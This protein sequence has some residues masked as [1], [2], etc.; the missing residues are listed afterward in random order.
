MN[1][2]YLLKIL[3]TEKL[4]ELVKL[5]DATPLE[6][7]LALW[8]AEAAGEIEI[9][10]DKD[11]VKLLIEPDMWFRART[12]EFATPHDSALCEKRN[13]YLAR[14]NEQSHQRSCHQFRLQ[15]ARVRHVDPVS[16]LT[17]AR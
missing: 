14:Q 9:D 3:E 16:R 10:R 12:H 2:S 15:N 8:D 17:V 5:I 6:M 11:Y 13:Q 1:V 7:N 4:S